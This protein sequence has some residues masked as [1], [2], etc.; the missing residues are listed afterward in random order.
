MA[1]LARNLYAEAACSLRKDMLMFIARALVFVLAS[2]VSLSVMAADCADVVDATA[3]EMKAGSTTWSDGRARIVRSAA[4]AACVKTASGRY[5]QASNTSTCSAVVENTLDELRAGAVGW[6]ASQAEA[7]RSAAASACIKTA[8]GRYA[9]TAAPA[10]KPG[11]SEDQAE[12]HDAIELVE[13]DDGRSG[14]RIGGVTIRPADA[15]PGRKPYD[16]H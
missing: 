9:D 16:H 13:D 8:S 11:P 4:G 2:G 7:A 10:D 6:Q 3:A 5:G 15:R 14:L 12:T 1:G